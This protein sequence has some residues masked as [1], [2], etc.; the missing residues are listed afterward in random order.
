MNFGARL[1]RAIEQRGRLCVGIDPHPAILEAWGLPV[2]VRGLER[3]ARQMVAA[4]G[5]QVAAFKPQSAL[6]E[7]F[8]SAGIAVLE[9][10]LSDIR[11]AGALSILDAKRGDI[12]STMAAYARAYLGDGPMAA[13]ALTVSPYLGFGSLQPAVE[14]ARDHG[15]GLFV[16]CRTSNPEGTQVQLARTGER[17]V[18]Q[19]IAD[20][21]TAA[22][23]SL[24]PGPFGLVIGGTRDSLGLA[25]ESFN[26]HILV[27]GIGAQGGTI[28]GLRA[29]FGPAAARVLPTSSRD[30]MGSG[31]QVPALREKVARTLSEIQG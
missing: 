26:G 23:Q 31:P 16:L 6:F 27:P 28:A 24:D 11:G 18:A 13:D 2:D 21:C 15:R 8:G 25:V 12:G 5:D 1:Q 19:L 17:T 20:E 14:M 30:I 7:V 9:R 3:C 29:L 4:V 22:N 10:V